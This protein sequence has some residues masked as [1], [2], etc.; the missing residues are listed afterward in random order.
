MAMVLL[1]LALLFVSM[2]SFEMVCWASLLL[3]PALRVLDEVGEP[4]FGLK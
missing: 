4:A 3:T 1:Q 2:V